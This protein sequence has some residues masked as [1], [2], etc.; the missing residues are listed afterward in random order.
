[1]FF[2][3]ILKKQQILSPIESNCEKIIAQFSNIKIKNM[4]FKNENKK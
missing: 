3:F 4:I 1:M 2:I